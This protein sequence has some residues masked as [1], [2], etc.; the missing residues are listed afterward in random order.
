VRRY[1][2]LESRG[3]HAL[4]PR[5][6]CWP[7][8]VPL[9]LENTTMQIIQQPDKITILYSDTYEVR[10]VR[11]NQ[12]HPA[13]VIPSWN[14]DSVGHYEDD[15]LVI[16]TVGIKVG[17]FPTPDLYAMVDWL[18]T[19]HTSALHVVERY[20]LLDHKTAKTI[21]ERNEEDNIALAMTD[22]GIRAIPIIKA[23]GWT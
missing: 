2:E 23:R 8:G 18:G 20:R 14:G 12:P 4:G 5:T 17:L 11:M 22:N 19:P 9:I 6:E 21:E 15:T 13:E 7:N 16:D 10:Q 1:G 3:I